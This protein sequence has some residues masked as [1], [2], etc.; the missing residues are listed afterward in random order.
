MIVFTGGIGEHDAAVRKA[1]CGRLGC[2]DIRLDEDANRS[3]RVRI[4]RADSAC[5]LRVFPSQEDEQI[6][7]HVGGLLQ[8]RTP[9]RPR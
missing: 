6:A 8:R 2:F 9:S 3:G 4:D 1:I 7:R 5:E